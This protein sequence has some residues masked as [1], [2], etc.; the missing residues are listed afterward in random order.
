MSARSRC[1]DARSLFSSLCSR[2]ST[3]HCYV[4]S[5]I[6]SSAVCCP[7]FA[8]RARVLDYRQEL[9][10]VRR[11][12]SIRKYMLNSQNPH[13]RVETAIYARPGGNSA[14]RHTSGGSHSLPIA[15]VLCGQG[16]QT[17]VGKVHNPPR[18]TTHRS[19]V[20]LTSLSQNLTCYFILAEGNLSYGKPSRL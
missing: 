7:V 20:A 6:G 4:I 8:W 17:C 5:L 3:A 2:Y 16:P 19:L 18:A 12:S 1:G 10:L 14:S 11:P 9:L 13:V 15:L